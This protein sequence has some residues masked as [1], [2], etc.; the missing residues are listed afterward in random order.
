MAKPGVTA[1]VL[2]SLDYRPI[3]SYSGGVPGLAPTSPS[4]TGQRLG[5]GSPAERAYEEHVAAI[6]REFESA[7]TAAIPE[8]RI[9]HRLRLVYGGVAVT[10]P[11]DRID[12]LRTLVH[13][14]DVQ[15]DRRMHV[16][17]IT[18]EPEEDG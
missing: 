17:A 16:H 9:T 18:L 15:P 3:A 7:L 6:E 13:V 14:V 8:A 11:A 12:E 2:V 4:V 5:R 10:L 1:G